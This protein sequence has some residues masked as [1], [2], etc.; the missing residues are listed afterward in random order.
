MTK[1]LEEL[2]DELL[3]L[4]SIH[5]ETVVDVSAPQQDTVN[6]ISNSSGIVATIQMPKGLMGV[7]WF[8]NKK[9]HT[10]KLNNDDLLGFFGSEPSHNSSLGIR[11]ESNIIILSKDQN[12]PRNHLYIYLDEN[13]RREISRI[14]LEN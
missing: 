1:D 13:K 9:Q 5:S 2:F 4:F 14:L 3:S 10:T 12:D 6:L 11:D 7:S 8:S